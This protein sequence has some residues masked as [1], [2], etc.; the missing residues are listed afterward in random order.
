MAWAL[1]SL[2]PW[3]LF[4]KLKIELCPS[5]LIQ[6]LKLDSSSHDSFKNQGLNTRKK[7]NEPFIAILSDL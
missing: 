7:V 3:M 5:K 4:P 2:T 6:K 1:K